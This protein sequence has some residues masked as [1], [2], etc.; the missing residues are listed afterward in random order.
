MRLNLAPVAGNMPLAYFP[1]VAAHT[2]LMAPYYDDP[3]E[4]IAR[5]ASPQSMDD[6]ALYEATEKAQAALLRW[7]N[8]AP[9]NP[10]LSNAAVMTSPST[11]SELRMPLNHCQ[12]SVSASPER[13]FQGGDGPTLLL[14][15][16]SAPVKNDKKRKRKEPEAVQ[17]KREESMPPPAKRA[18]RA[19]SVAKAGSVA[20]ESSNQR[21]TGAKC[22]TKEAS[23]TPET[24]KSGGKNPKR[25]TAMKAA[26]AKRQAE[27]R[28]GR[29]GGA[30]L[31][32]TVA[33]SVAKKGGR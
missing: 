21:S 29:H 31:A 19:Q 7:Q 8:H 15:A 1:S 24:T 27:G 23:V 32:S 5:L 12:P 9:S 2:Q 28:N 20:P 17:I 22:A 26:W 33:K 4:L 10:N 6:D 18:T 25:S 14:D 3:D 11:W 16:D 30:P 13:I